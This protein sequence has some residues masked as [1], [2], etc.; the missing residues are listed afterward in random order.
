M[1]VQIGIMKV[2]VNIK[3]LMLIDMPAKSKKTRKTGSYGSLYKQKAQNIRTSVDVRGESLDD[4]VMDVEKYID[5][6]IYFGS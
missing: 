2:G 5:E 1:Q 6:R 4:A 3:D